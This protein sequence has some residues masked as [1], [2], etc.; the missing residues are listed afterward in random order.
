LVEKRKWHG[1]AKYEIEVRGQLGS[2]WSDWFDDIT[3]ESYSG[4]TT[5]TIDILDQAA[6]HGL[7]AR[8]RDLGLPLISVR[9]ICN[10]LKA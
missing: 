10:G 2:Q 8:I 7:L 6:L 5:I 3:I 4:M 1:P 9:R